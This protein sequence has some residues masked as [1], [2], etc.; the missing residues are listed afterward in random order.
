MAAKP[1]GTS[2]GIGKD[3]FIH[4]CGFESDLD[5]D[6]L[7]GVGKA[8]G[9]KI[10]ALGHGKY[11]PAVRSEMLRNLFPCDSGFQLFQAKAVIDR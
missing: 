3:S 1:S 11:Q 7:V 10:I 2:L 6:N 5:H 9:A 8:G 4:L